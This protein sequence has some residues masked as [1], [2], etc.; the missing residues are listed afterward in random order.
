MTELESIYRPIRDD[1][2]KVES[3]LAVIAQQMDSNLAEALGGALSPRGKRLRPALLIFSSRLG[4]GGADVSRPAAA[5]ELVHSAALLHDDVVDHAETRRGSV[6][7]SKK[8]GQSAALVLGNY[9]YSKAFELMP[10]SNGLRQQLSAATSMMCSGEALELARRRDLKTGLGDYIHMAGKKTASLTSACCSIGAVLGQADPEVC[11]SLAAYGLFLGLAYQIRDDCLDLKGEKET[12]GKG[13]YRDFAE[14]NATLPLIVALPSMNEKEKQ[15]ASSMF[16]G[17]DEID[18]AWLIETLERYDGI[19][20]SVALA[21][22]F[23]RKAAMNLEAIP[24]SETK[25]S[26]RL[27]T[28]YCVERHS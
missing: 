14:G 6:A 5:L 28:A 25:E 23:S 2:N 12:T 18:T 4:N 9:L 13:C 8:L 21:E 17:S 27:L 10:S 26:L 11:C 7:A 24:D 15:R 16:K 22:E 19:L 1:L 3:V 20:K